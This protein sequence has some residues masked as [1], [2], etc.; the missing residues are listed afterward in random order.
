MAPPDA[1]GCQPDQPASGAALLP[2]RVSSAN[3]VAA[4]AEPAG[5]EG[6]GREGGGALACRA[7]GGA[8]VGAGPTPARERRPAGHGGGPAG[9]PG[10]CAPAGGQAAGVELLADGRSE[11][12][13]A[14]ASG[15]GG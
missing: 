7:G 11:L 6:G 8:G 5:R 1:T 10:R 13:L 3:A 14:V 2:E 15:C 4:G 9:A 12:D